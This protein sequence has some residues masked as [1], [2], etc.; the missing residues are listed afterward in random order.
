MCIVHVTKLRR[1]ISGGGGGLAG[2]EGGNVG[3]GFCGETGGKEATWIDGT[4]VPKL[5]FKKYE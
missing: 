1:I 3:R 2:T 5:I 4:I